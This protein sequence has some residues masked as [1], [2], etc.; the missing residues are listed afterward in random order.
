VAVQEPC[1]AAFGSKKVRLNFLS[2]ADDVEEFADSDRSAEGT[3]WPAR[4][5]VPA[6]VRGTPLRLI[7]TTAC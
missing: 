2:S 6:R 7:P 4:P 3:Q 5:A 1:R